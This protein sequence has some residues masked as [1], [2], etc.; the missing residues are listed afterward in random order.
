MSAV[1][2][3][4]AGFS[5]LPGLAERE[6]LAGAVGEQVGGGGVC[7]G[8]ADS[9]GN[10]GGEYTSKTLVIP[11]TALN[12]NTQTMP[13]WK[14]FLPVFAICTDGKFQNFSSPHEILR[15]FLLVKI[16]LPLFW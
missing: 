9:H 1:L 11:P 6:V 3:P 14:W 10:L 4:P 2:K 13:S 5:P 16:K 12:V 15:L 7:D 8:A